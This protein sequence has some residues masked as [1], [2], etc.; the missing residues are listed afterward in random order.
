[1][2]CRIPKLVLQP[3]IEYSVKY[4]FG[5][6]E[7]LKVEIKAYIHEDRLIMICRD[8]GI[9]MTPGILGELTALLEQEENNSR[10]FRTL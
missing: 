8:D 10:Y 3:M 9:G 7:N 5:N 1:M 4:G 6:P 2:C